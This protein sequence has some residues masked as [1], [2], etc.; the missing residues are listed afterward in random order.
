MRVPHRIP[1]MLCLAL[2]IALPP[3]AQAKGGRVLHTEAEMAQFRENLAQQGWV[4]GQV[5]SAVQAAAP[6]V[7]L[8]DQELWDF[9]PAGTVPRSVLLNRDQ[10]CPVH[11]LRIFEG[12]GFYPWRWSP[13]KPYKVQCPVGDEWYPSNDFAA[14]LAAAGDQGV[15]GQVDTHQKYNDDGWGYV[16]EQGHRYWFVAFY[17]Q[18][19]WHTRRNV[20]GLLSRAYL[21]TGEAKYAHKAAVALA[22][23]ATIYPGMHYAEQSDGLTGAGR[24]LYGQWETPTVN[25]LAEPY[26]DIYPY[27]AAGGDPE[28]TAFLAAKQIS[29]PRTHIEQGLLQEFAKALQTNTEMTPGV[30]GSNDWAMALLAAVWD[31]NDPAHGMTTNQM[32]DWAWRG[33]GWNAES[34]IHNDTYRDGFECEEGLGYNFEMRHQLMEMARLF[35]RAGRDIWG[36]PKLRKLLDAPLDVTILNRFTPA[37]GD[38]G[39]LPFAGKMGWDPALYALAFRIY[40]DPR[41]AKVAAPSPGGGNAMFEK[42]PGAEAR[43]VI[44]EQGTD[45]SLQTR[46]LAGFGLGIL[47]RGRGD[48]G[49]ALSLWYGSS[50]G[51][52]SHRDRLNLELWAHGASLAPDF[53]YPEHW[54]QPRNVEWIS[55]TTSHNTVLVNAEGQ[56]E[57][58]WNGPGSGYLTLFKRSPALDVIEAEGGAAYKGIVS[59]YRRLTALIDC[60]AGGGYALDIFRVQGGKQHDYLFHGNHADFTFAGG[61]L[62]APDTKGTVAGPDVPPETEYEGKLSGFQFLYNPQRATPPGVWSGTWRLRN[63]DIGLRLTMLPGCAQEAIVADG[64]PPWHS[65][66]PVKFIV[67]RN[68]GDNL[69]S[70]YAAVLEPFRG[71]PGLD[72]T[73]LQPREADPDFVAVRVQ[74]MGVTHTLLC[75]PAETAGKLRQVE[76]GFSFA[77]QV[78]FVAARDGITER[79]LLTNGTELSCGKMQLRGAG[80]LRGRVKGMDYQGNA[81]IVDQDLSAGAA[82]VGETVVFGNEKRHS[83]YEIKGV[84]K[85]AAGWAILLGDTITDVCQCEVKEIDPAKRTLK[86]DTPILLYT[87]GLEFPGMTFVNEART[88]S[89]RVEAFDAIGHTGVNTPPFGGVATLA[90]TPDLRGTFTDANGDGRT[91]FYVYEFG[92][93]DSFEIA[94][95]AYAERLNPW[96]FRLQGTGRTT[97]VLPVAGAA[98]ETWIKCGAGAWTKAK[99]APSPAGTCAVALDPAQTGTGQAFVAVA[100]PAW[101]DLDDHE[102]PVVER[103]LV[104]GQEV[105]DAAVIELGRR[106]GLST[107]VLEVADARNPLDPDS[108]SV[109]LDGRQYTVKDPQVKFEPLSADKRRARLTCALPVETPASLRGCQAIIDHQIAIQVDD[110]AVDDARLT[111]VINFA[112]VSPPPEHVVYLSDLQPTKIFVHGYMTDRGLNAPNIVL[113]GVAY[114]RGV[115]AHPEI[116]QPE[117]HSEIVYDLTKLKEYGTFHAVV[118]VE[119][120]AGGGSVEFKVQTRRGQGEW[121]ELWKSGVLRVGQESK[122]V[123]CPLQGADE[124]RLY[125]TDGG[126][127]YSCDHAFWA[128]ARVQ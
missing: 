64:D 16:D 118:G 124:L 121:T 46:N 89:C 54:T 73:R 104:D 77:G 37:M 56:P 74:G 109:T 13:D 65:G 78:G 96:A 94:N 61:E 66:G 11:G 110:Y 128:D 97:L 63:Q 114:A 76:G 52:H 4:Q 3:C 108:V 127:G 41:Y 75:S 14:Q 38:S 67:A 29:D 95:S 116:A 98:G 21:L 51:G 24:I 39:G 102:P 81:V 93:G 53:G 83:N 90:G 113:H 79:M 45:L 99:L 100:K 92:P 55:N 122:L 48:S 12:R 6:W 8:T 33:V 88:A 62:S 28:L 35:Q 84:E 7:K 59:K 68:R 70:T 43:R 123:E 112:A 85:R 80:P 71:Q 58:G 111:R 34:L 40:H 107:L 19:Y 115:F 50:G 72:V 15:K 23:L 30:Q 106:A 60:S 18:W 126:D 44:Q 57:A 9:F 31:D 2:L 101:L 120:A 69:S 105:K 42:D 22:R 32:L 119:D 20:P 47:E 125:V 5:Q 87:N 91:E 86:T 49:R 26:D 10:G 82:L 117:T 27:L 103:V 17:N 1:A 25:A 36:E